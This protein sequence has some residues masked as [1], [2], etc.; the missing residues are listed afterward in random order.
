MGSAEGR[1]QML[2]RHEIV[3]R[4]IEANSRRLQ[5]ENEIN[6]LDIE[7]RIAERDLT[8]TPNDGEILARLAEIESK[9]SALQIESRKLETDRDWLDQSLA[10]FDGLPPTGN[11]TRGRA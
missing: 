5:L 6:G 11:Q 7:R 9:I 2:Q 3:V 8:A 1:Q 10:D 4:I